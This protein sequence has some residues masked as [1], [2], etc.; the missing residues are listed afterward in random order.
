MSGLPT[1][2]DGPL[3][4][5]W[6]SNKG[7]PPQ[8]AAC[9]GEAGQSWIHTF[10]SYT[11]RQLLN[12]TVP[13]TMSPDYLCEKS[14][15]QLSMLHLHGYVS[16]G[17]CLASIPS[18]V[19]VLPQHVTV[20]ANLFPCTY[21]PSTSCLRSST[22]CLRN[23]T[24]VCYISTRSMPSIYNPCAVFV[25][26]RHVAVPAYLFHAPSV[27][28][29]LCS[30]ILMPMLL[31]IW[32]PYAHLWPY[33]LHLQLP[34][35]SLNGGNVCLATLH[36]SDRDLQPFYYVYMNAHVRLILLHSSTSTFFAKIFNAV[37]E[38]PCL[39]SS[40]KHFFRTAFSQ[41]WFIQDIQWTLLQ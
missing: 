20:P 24:P 8:H 31:Y 14:V 38:H 18:T 30:S 4:P 5:V 12:V 40:N 15:N 39:P 17:L 1:R 33:F 10:P 35:T 13:S 23:S 22:W 21:S 34:N 3:P 16:T 36:S 32:L 9:G 25:L 29:R 27:L 6:G 7:F 26:L 41:L 11:L 37:N 28:L 2:T 19:Y